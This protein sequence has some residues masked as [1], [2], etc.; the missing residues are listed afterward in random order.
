MGRGRRARPAIG[1]RSTIPPQNGDPFVEQAA[2]AGV[3][4]GAERGIGAEFGREEARQIAAVV[5]L[6][7]QHR[8]SGLR[9]R[10]QALRPGL[11]ER[12]IRPIEDVG[13][14]VDLEAL[15]LIDR[16]ER[17]LEELDPRVL[18]KMREVERRIFIA[19]AAEEDV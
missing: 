1:G 8:A 12:I 4:L 5:E 16:F 18:W 9:S 14:A 19:I 6:A 17:A 3:E 15:E 10:F 13:E 11:H 2:I 7:D